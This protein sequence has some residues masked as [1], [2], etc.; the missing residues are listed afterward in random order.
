MIFK[1]IKKK[2]TRL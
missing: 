2:S 1:F